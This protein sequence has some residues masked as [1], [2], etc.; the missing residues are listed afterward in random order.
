MVWDLNSE[1]LDPNTSSYQLWNLGKFF[2]SS[3]LN[4]FIYKMEMRVPTSQVC[5]MNWISWYRL[6]KK[7]KELCKQEGIRQILGIIISPSLLVI[8]VCA[9]N[10][11]DCLGTMEH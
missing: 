6:K 4:F 8:C 3:N 5:Y 1:D 9:L 11:S 7:K 10:I 2:T